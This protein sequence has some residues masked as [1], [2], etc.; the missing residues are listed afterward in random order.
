MAL[1]KEERAVVDRLLSL[2]SVG[3]FHQCYMAEHDDVVYEANALLNQPDRIAV[4]D[5][6]PGGKRLH[7]PAGEQVPNTGQA[8]ILTVPQWALSAKVLAAADEFD[9]SN[10]AR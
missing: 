8:F 4:S 7:N 2:I 5:A 6:L 9:R 3:D 10:N 1:N